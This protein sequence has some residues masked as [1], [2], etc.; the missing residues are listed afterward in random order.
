MGRVKVTPYSSGLAQAINVYS[1]DF[2]CEDSTHNPFYIGDG[3]ARAQFAEASDALACLLYAAKPNARD[4]LIAKK[5]DRRW[6]FVQCSIGPVYGFVISASYQMGQGEAALE[7]SKELD[8][9][10]LIATAIPPFT[11]AGGPE[12]PRH[13]AAFSRNGVPRRFRFTL[14]RHNSN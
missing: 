14:R 6:M 3:R 12:V 10:G 8:Q 5:V 13:N 2:G 11:I 7:N 4:G 1:Q 9:A